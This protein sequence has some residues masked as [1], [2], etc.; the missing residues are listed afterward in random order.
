MILWE[1]VNLGL[2]GSLTMVEITMEKDVCVYLL[3]E[4]CA[5]LKAVTKS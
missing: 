2:S 5:F 1:I 3:Q 4:H